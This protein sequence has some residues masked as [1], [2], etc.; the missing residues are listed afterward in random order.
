MDEMSTIKV[1][2]CKIGEAPREVDVVAGST[3]ERA[4]RV[5][6]IDTFGFNFLLSGQSVTAHAD[7]ELYEDTVI[8]VVKADNIVSGR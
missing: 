6:N 3:I 5:A 2:F 1:K 7:T 8:V 4:A